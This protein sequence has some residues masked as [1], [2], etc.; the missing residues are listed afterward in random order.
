MSYTTIDQVRSH[1]VPIFPVLEQVSDAPVVIR[2]TEYMTFHAGSVD[3]SSVVVK[4]QRDGEQTRRTVT[5]SN[6]EAT[7]L[8]EL[9]VPGSVVLASDSSLGR[10]YVE[11]RDYVADYASGVLRLKA[12]STV[13][14][15]QAVVAWYVPYEVYHAGVDYRL[16]SEKGMIARMSGGAIAEGETV[17]IDFV[18]LQAGF[19]ENAITAAV[20]EANGQ[21]ERDVDPGREFGADPVLVSAATYRALT[22]VCR[23][24][25]ARELAGPRGL[26]RIASGWLKLGEDYT[27][28]ADRLLREF[29]APLTGP[30]SPTRS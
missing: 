17:F 30:S 24:A 20:R 19:D 12:G 16:N 27:T 1:L 15:D 28:M 10:V 26:D 18:P 2:G 21:V 8:G 25:A 29:R 4:S 22:I 9:A 14:P 3:E 5:F 23:T 7:L 11:N 6:G 13:G